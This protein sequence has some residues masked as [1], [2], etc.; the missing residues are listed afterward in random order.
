MWRTHAPCVEREALLS[1]LNVK[2]KKIFHN[3]LSAQKIYCGICFFV[4]SKNIRKDQWFKCNVWE[5]FTYFLI[6]DCVKHLFDLGGGLCWAADWSRGVQWIVTECSKTRF[7]QV[8]ILLE[9]VQKKLF[10]VL[11]YHYETLKAT[12][13]VDTYYSE[14]GVGGLHWNEL[15]VCGESFIQPDVVPP[16]HGHQVT[17]PLQASLVW[18]FKKTLQVRR[19]KTSVPAD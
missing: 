17:K 18:I 12:V 19:R 16:P 8:F 2:G 14:V 11:L 10:N 9:H 1:R 4:Q 6:G 7:Q 13:T 5:S 15:H 3:Y